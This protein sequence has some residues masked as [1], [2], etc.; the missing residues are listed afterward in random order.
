[1]EVPGQRYRTSVHHYPE[2]LPV[3]HYGAGVFVRRVGSN[4]MISF[5][6]WIQKVGKAFIGLD[7]AVRP[8]AE[9]GVFSV[10]FGPEVIK[11]FDV[12]ETDLQ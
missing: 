7:V 6:G 8:E 11:Q 5:K 1:M 2:T 9:D 3:V 12:R 4:G 10:L